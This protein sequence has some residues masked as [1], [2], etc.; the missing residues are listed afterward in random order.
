MSLS[1]A[2]T[3]YWGIKLSSH[4]S[5]RYSVSGA[6]HDLLS[7][8]NPP[9]HPSPHCEAKRSLWNKTHAGAGKCCKSTA[10]IAEEGA[11]VNGNLS[12]ESLLLPSPGCSLVALRLS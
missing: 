8:A 2:T 9:F 6:G 11:A 4:L 12:T 7:N 10:A 3:L 1:R 5:E